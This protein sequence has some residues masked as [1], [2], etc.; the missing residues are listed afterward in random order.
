MKK[1]VSLILAA[2]MMLTLAVSASADPVYGGTLRYG[3]ANGLSNAGYTPLLAANAYVPYIQLAYEN[4][5]T[6]DNAGNLVGKLATAW[7]LDPEALTITW[8]LREGVQF[9]DGTPFNAEAVR[10]NIEEYQKNNRT[11]TANIASMEVVDDKTIVMTMAELNSSTLESVGFFVYYVS[12]ASLA[13]Q[14][15]ID[16]LA[17]STNGTGPF[18]LA[19]FVAN[20]Y[21]IYDKNPNYWQEGKPYLDSVSI[22]LIT[23]VST[24]QTAFMAEE[25]DLIGISNFNP[26]SLQE[27]ENTGMYNV[28]V[29]ENGMGIGT[30][31]LI[32]NS[33]IDSPWSN[34]L[35]RRAMCYAIDVDALNAAFM[36]GTGTIVDE[37]A[38][39]DAV[40]YNKDLT[41]MTYNPERAKELLAEAGYAD[42]FDTVIVSLSSLNDMFTAIANMLGKVGIRCTINTVDGATQNQMYM[43]GTWEGL[44]PHWTTVSPDLGLYMGRHLDYNGAYYAKGI[45]HPDKEMNLLSAIRAETDPEKK[46]TLEKELQAAIYDAEEGSILFGR[47]LFVNSSKFFTQPWVNG[48]HIAECFSSGWDLADCW[49]SEH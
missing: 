41:H 26:I 1:V 49:L 44:M 47:P 15:G 17:T 42:G 16:A 6:Y 21:A 14:E 33:K 8:T 28:T 2:I 38:T 25:Y 32:P 37:W 40:T 9:A 31:G 5:I 10:I 13:T 39:P 12:P 29:N 4:L 46:H 34:E 11:E 27:L 35:V 20:S 23:E 43:D 18:Q 36:L 19:E 48:G 30:L 45:L 24:M 7:E 22:T 3:Y